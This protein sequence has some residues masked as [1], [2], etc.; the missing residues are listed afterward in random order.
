MK[1]KH[2]AVVYDNENKCCL[3]A[4]VKLMSE[5]EYKNAL[6][7]VERHKQEEEKR[8]HKLEIM[9]LD[10]FKDICAL[11]SHD[12][13]L[14]KAIYDKFVDRGYFDDDKEFEKAFYDFMFED[15][16]LNESL[17]PSEFLKILNKVVVKNEK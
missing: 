13:Y 7:E 12:I 5:L 9:E 1:D 16:E 2:V 10:N 17:F 8:L 14:A 11:K 6:N 4:K 3:V 15:K